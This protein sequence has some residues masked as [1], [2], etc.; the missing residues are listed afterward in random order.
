M[1]N[2]RIVIFILIYNR[3]KYVDFLRN[4]HLNAVIVGSIP[5]RFMDVRFSSVCWPV[6][7]LAKGLI[8]RPR[9]HSDCLYDP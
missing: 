9:K 5:I 8:S 2:A 1:D 3:H 7:G 4:S 6:C